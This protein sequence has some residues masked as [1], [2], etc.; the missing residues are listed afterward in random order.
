MKFIEYKGQ[1]HSLTLV[2]SH[3]D[4]I[5]KLVFPQKQLGDLEPKFV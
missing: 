1:G 4:F 3:S 2:K 5:V